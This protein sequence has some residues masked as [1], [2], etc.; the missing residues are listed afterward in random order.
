ML[1]ILLNL[2]NFDVMI[3][4]DM[5]RPWGKHL[6]D[7]ASPIAEGILEVHD[8]VMFYLVL[9]L[10]LVGYLTTKIIV[11]F[12]KNKISYKYLT[13]GSTL[14]FIW[15]LFPIVI[16]SL[17]AF[18]SFILLYLTDD[19]I[20][21]AM[22]IKCI[23]YQW[24]WSYEY[25]DFINDSNETISFDSY[26]IP[27]EMLEFGQLRLLDVDTRVV[28]PVDTHIRFIVTGGDVIHSFTV[29]SLGFKVD[30]TP[31]RLL[32]ISTIIQREGRF[33]GQCSE[34]CGVA[35]SEMPITIEAVSLPKF[36]DWL[37]EQ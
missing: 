6:Q 28:V 18:P 24:Y 1:N 20:D 34:I 19:V 21:P 4:N 10:V 11:T 16:L 23:G 2:I 15:T 33:Y 22:T 9:I 30:A 29:P 8:T 35:H 7:S 37:N 25:S 32:Q 36:L 31:G 17:I 26:L 12:S 5:P 14:E 27:E 13:H 3:S